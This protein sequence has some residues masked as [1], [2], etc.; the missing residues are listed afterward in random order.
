MKTDGTASGWCAESAAEL[1]EKYDGFGSRPQSNYALPAVCVAGAEETSASAG[2]RDA[3]KSK[4]K[5]AAA[6]ASASTFSAPS[7][8]TSAFASATV[9][10]ATSPPSESPSEHASAHSCVWRTSRLFRAGD[11]VLLTLDC[12]HLTTRNV[13]RPPSYRL[14]ADTRWLP[15]HEPLDSRV[16]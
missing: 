1:I 10:S 14:S 6:S 4:R 16:H 5:S 15:A 2:S 3:K 13:Q 9:H 12:L 8:S 11:I 7:A